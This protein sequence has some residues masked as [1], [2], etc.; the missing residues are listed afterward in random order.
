MV[1]TE[2]AWFGAG[3]VATYMFYLNW[4]VRRLEEVIASFP[5]IDEIAK[6]VLSAKVGSEDIPPEVAA[7]FASLSGGPPPSKPGD[8]P[9]YMG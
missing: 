9:S 6:E 2:A 1:M 4:R 5:S 8:K 3:I 7:A